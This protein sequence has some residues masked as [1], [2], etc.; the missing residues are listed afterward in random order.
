MPSS[1]LISNSF[2]Q[3]TNNGALVPL[4]N[5][6]SPGSASSISSVCAGYSTPI[7]KNSGSPHYS[8]EDSS[9]L[10]SGEDKNFVD[11]VSSSE[12]QASETSTNE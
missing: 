12:T 2:G 3:P 10:P 9:S 6:A 7:R 5:L 8:K 1:P 11:L 4:D